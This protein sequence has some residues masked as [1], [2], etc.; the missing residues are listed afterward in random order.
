MKRVASFVGLVILIFVVVFVYFYL[1]DV[2]NLKFSN[3]DEPER[4]ME[5]LEVG[6]ELMVMEHNSGLYTFWIFMAMFILIFLKVT[7]KLIIYNWA[8]NK[9]DEEHV[10]ESK[11]KPSH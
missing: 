6:K 7:W 11:Y 2:E 5:A 10:I 1:Y 3:Q 4:L 8:W 9:L